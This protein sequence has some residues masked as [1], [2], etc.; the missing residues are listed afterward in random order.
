MR[1]LKVID[2]VS[3]CPRGSYSSTASTWNAQIPPY[4]RS[5]IHQSS[6]SPA[7]C[8]TTWTSYE[9]IHFSPRDLLPNSSYQNI[10][11]ITQGSFFLSGFLPTVWWVALPVH[12][13]PQHTTHCFISKPG[14]LGGSLLSQSNL[15]WR[16]FAFH[17]LSDHMVNYNFP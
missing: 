11:C 5:L 3:T 17:C 12:F 4:Q 16:G 8:L 15:S 13:F 7:S 1:L 6:P 14:N 10:S 2:N 9:A